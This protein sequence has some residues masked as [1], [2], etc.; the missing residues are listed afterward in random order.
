MSEQSC[1]LGSREGKHVAGWP[2]WCVLC[3]PQGTR[4]WWKRQWRKA[5]RRNAKNQIR[6]EQ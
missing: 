5:V 3:R 1:K 4:K 2:C 6:D